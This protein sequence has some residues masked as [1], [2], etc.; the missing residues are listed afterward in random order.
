[1]AIVDRL[2]TALLTIWGVTEIV[3]S[4]ISFRN[5][6][7][8][9]SGGADRFSHFAVWLATIPPLFFAALMRARFAHGFGSLSPLFPALG[10]LGCLA[11]TLGI[12]LRVIAVATLKK[13][14]TVRVAIVEHH[15]IV[16]TGIYGIIRHP[17]YLGHLAS[18]LG[19]GLLSENWISL[20]VSIIL[21]VAAILYRIHVEEAALVRHFGPAY[22]VYARRTKRLLPGIW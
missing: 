21:P 11:L 16:D 2:T 9:S 3:I 17:S 10:Y 19:M 12:T 5:R 15:Q 7:K 20:I 18:L 14:F 4:L 22:Q 8:A 13:Q 6:P 1:M